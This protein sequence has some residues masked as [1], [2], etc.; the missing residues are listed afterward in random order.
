MLACECHVALWGAVRD[1]SF[2]LNFVS[3]LTICLRCCYFYPFLVVKYLLTP[4]HDVIL[5]GYLGHFDVFLARILA[6]LFRKR[7]ILNFHISLYDTVVLDRKLVGKGSILAKGLYCV[8]KLACLLADKVIVDTEAYAKFLQQEF[9]IDPDKL[10]CAYV[11]LPDSNIDLKN[12]R[13]KKDL[14]QDGVEVLFYGQFIPLH[15]I[16]Y[17]L[18][19]CQ[20]FAVGG[21]C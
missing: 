1:K 2:S 8:D 19:G 20:E 21:K 3:L 14:V 18:E 6:I 9:S 5:V 7:V 13:T 10:I 12:E 11:G 15:G 17:I 4:T 16:Q